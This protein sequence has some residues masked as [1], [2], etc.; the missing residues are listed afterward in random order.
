MSRRDWQTDWGLTQRFKEAG[1]T[2]GLVQQGNGQYGYSFIQ[3][4]NGV[5]VNDR[6][7]PVWFR[8]AYEGW[9]AALEERARLAERVRELEEENHRLWAIFKTCP[10]CANLVAGDL[11]GC[12]HQD[13]LDGE[14]PCNWFDREGI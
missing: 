6:L 12:Y 5:F 4:E 1:Y 9:P 11:S 2:I 7:I 14:N 8:A 3:A 13:H 10:G